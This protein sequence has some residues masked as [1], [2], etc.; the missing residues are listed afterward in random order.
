MET[1]NAAGATRA[2]SASQF[3]ANCLQLIDQVA[4]FGGEIV[5]TKHGIPAAR[6]A[7]LTGNR[8]PTPPFGAGRHLFEITGDIEAPLDVEWEAEANPDRVLDPSRFSTQT[9]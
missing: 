1:H 9:S 8:K 5:I 2:I 7:P 6:L 3:R 4:Q